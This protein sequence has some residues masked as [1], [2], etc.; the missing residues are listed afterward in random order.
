MLFKDRLLVAAMCVLNNSTLVLKLKY[1]LSTSF[2]AVF[3]QGTEQAE[4]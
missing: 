3:V 1:A 4:I 2:S